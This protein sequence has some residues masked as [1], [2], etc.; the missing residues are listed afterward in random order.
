MG[1]KNK[2]KYSALRY[3]DKPEIRPV[4]LLCE[5][6]IVAGH[7]ENLNPIDSMVMAM[8]MGMSMGLHQPDTA[9]RITDAA[10]SVVNG[11]L[12]LAADAGADVINEEGEPIEPEPSKPTH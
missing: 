6:L 10:N 2:K 7:A 9:T 11:A 5:A 1:K 8:L 4:A 12:R 3:R